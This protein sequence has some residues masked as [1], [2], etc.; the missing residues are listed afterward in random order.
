MNELPSAKDGEPVAPGSSRFGVSGGNLLAGGP[1]PS[2][3]ERIAVRRAYAE[4]RLVLTKQ[5]AKESVALK[6]SKKRRAHREVRRWQSTVDRMKNGDVGMRAEWAL[7]WEETMES[8]RK[9]VEA[10]KD[11]RDTDG[12]RVATY[13]GEPPMIFPVGSPYPELIE[14]LRNEEGD[15]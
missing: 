4:K 10:F 3:P 12:Q 9:S 1:E 15:K 13:E 11:F 5:A 14:K 2:T 8:F 7:Q 6:K